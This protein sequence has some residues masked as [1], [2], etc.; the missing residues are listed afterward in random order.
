MTHLWGRRRSLESLEKRR[1]P[2]SHILPQD[3]ARRVLGSTRKPS[4]RVEK[5][6]ERGRLIWRSGMSTF[7]ETM[8]SDK[9][10][11]VPVERRSATRSEVKFSRQIDKNAPGCEKYSM[12]LSSADIRSLAFGLSVA[13]RHSEIWVVEAIAQ[14]AS[15]RD[16]ASGQTNV[17]SAFTCGKL[18]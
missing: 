14:G 12:S 1:P 3:D 13:A 8:S 4:R 16:R 9:A 10:R 6:E 15:G 11:D 2:L 18:I 5:R 17:K 7:E